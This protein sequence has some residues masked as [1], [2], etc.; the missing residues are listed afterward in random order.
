M[1]L[2]NMITHSNDK[3]IE[4]S[5]SIVYKEMEYIDSIIIDAFTYST[6][7]PYKN[8]EPKLTTNQRKIKEFK[9]KANLPDASDNDVKKLIRKCGGD[10]DKAVSLILDKE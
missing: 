5:K 10:V 4:V 7:L 3:N 8:P 2:E 9:E 6:N 1:S